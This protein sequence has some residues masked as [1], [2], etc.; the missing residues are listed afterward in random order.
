[1]SDASI[2]PTPSRPIPVEDATLVRWPT[3]G[4][5]AGADADADA[6][7]PAQAPRPTGLRGA[8]IKT[9]S[10]RPSGAHRPHPY[11][12]LQE[13]RL[14]EVVPHLHK[15]VPKDALPGLAG[16]PATG[17]TPSEPPNLQKAGAGGGG[18]GLDAASERTRR[19]AELLGRSAP[20][21]IGERT[22]HLPDNMRLSHREPPKG[23]T[24]LPGSRPDWSPGPYSYPG[25][26][27]H[28][29]APSSA[30]PASSP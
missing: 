12:R 4:A 7:G 8:T 14:A 18:P 24:R 22:L 15:P 25:H 11:A 13:P 29:H 28:D 2:V 23:I 6:G 1:M 27:D 5:G 10:S 20:L 21:R 17:P 26:H 3:T 19:F 16:R 30:S 9:A